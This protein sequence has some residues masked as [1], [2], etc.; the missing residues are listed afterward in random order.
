MELNKT[1]NLF[2]VLTLIWV[3]LLLGLGSWWLFLVY[4]LHSTLSLLKATDLGLSASFINM[5]KWEGSFFFILLVLL[6][7]SLLVMYLRDMKK[8][9]S[10][11]AFFS[12]LTHEL[13]TPLASVRLQAEVIKDLIEDESHDHQQL[14][15]L[16][17][18][19]IEDSYKLESELEKS[20]Q[21]SRLEQGGP[22]NLSP[23]NLERFIKK[24]VQKFPVPLPLEINVGDHLSEVMADEIALGVIFRNLFENTKRHNP[25][26]TLI[27]IDI[28]IKDESLELTYDDHGK[29]FAGSIKQLGELF[30]K[31]NSTKGS[32][33][34]LYLVKHLMIKMKGQLHIQNDERL[35]FKLTFKVPEGVSDVQ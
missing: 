22:L 12:S 7:A 33:I 21:I 9:R 29:F 15:N 20:L 32:G 34:G 2:F 6:G 35:V 24:Q 18:R 23:I 14:S 19:L 25:Q 8:S 16:A 5:I 10:I 17:K 11:Q 27:S 31:F 3:L 1:R 26:T 30:Y 28:Q 4:K 13:K